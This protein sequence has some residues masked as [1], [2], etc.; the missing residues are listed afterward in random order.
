MGMR[1]EAWCD[2]LGVWLPGVG[3]KCLGVMIVTCGLWPRGNRF[4]PCSWGKGDD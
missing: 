3:G 4:R 2:M 1:R